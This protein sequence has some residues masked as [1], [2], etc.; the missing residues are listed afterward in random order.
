M[1][2]RR[3]ARSRA[4]GPSVSAPASRQL[5]MFSHCPPHH[6]PAAHDFGPPGS[7]HRSRGPPALPGQR[8]GGSRLAPLASSHFHTA[9]LLQRRFRSM[10]GSGATGKTPARSRRLIVDSE[11]RRSSARSAR[12]STS[13]QLSMSPPWWSRR[14]LIPLRPTPLRCTSAAAGWSLLECFAIPFGFSTPDPGS[15]R[16]NG[17]PDGTQ[18]VASATLTVAHA[19]RAPLGLEGAWEVYAITARPTSPGMYDPAAHPADRLRRDSRRANAGRTGRRR[20]GRQS[21]PGTR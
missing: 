2:R 17:D 9:A 12:S 6:R 15:V 7:S 11:Q 13:G 20:Y 8:L 18:R 19:L 4:S 21:Q 10:P 14:R 1:P 5:R 16:C 3:D